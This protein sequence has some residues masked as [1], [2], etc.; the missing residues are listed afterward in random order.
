[1]IGL[2]IV[3][4]TIFIYDFYANTSLNNKPEKYDVKN[5]VLVTIDT[6]RSDH[7]G[8]YGYPVDTTPF[9][10]KLSKKS[11]LFKNAYAQVSSTKPSH[12]SIFTSLYPY[13]HGVLSNGKVLNEGIPTLAE[14][15]RTNGYMTYG[16]TA[17]KYKHNK[18]DLGFE[19]L[20][21]VD[22]TE[23]DSKLVRF[24]PN[25]EYKHRKASYLVDRVISKFKNND[26]SKKFIWVHFYDVHRPF[27]PPLK[28]LKKIKETKVDYL[29]VLIEDQK[30][31]AD[32]YSAKETE[33]VKK[34]Q[35][36]DGEVNFV[37]KELSRL[38][39][40]FKKVGLNKDSLWIITSDHGEGLGNHYFGRHGDAIYNEQIKVPFILHLDSLK[41]KSK[42]I[43]AKIDHVD[44]LPTVL[45]LLSLNK[46][47]PENAQ[48]VSLK[49][50]LFVSSCMD[51]KYIFSRT[52]EFDK[53]TAKS[54]LEKG[55]KYSCSTLKYKYIYET[56]G[57]EYL[58]DLKLDPHELK[59]IASKK[60]N[61]VK[62]LKSK[63]YNNYKNIRPILS[64][65]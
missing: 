34:V 7:V 50:C 55:D 62:K 8:C 2:I 4:S 49:S 28:H 21:Q 36:Y 16:I 64:Q 40:H 13:Q 26:K 27:V 33:L 6:L 25:N 58:F 57:N 15:L 14:I 29:K 43:S 46:S 38:Y 18:L 44:I 65:H 63:I 1:M 10:D 12:A 51:K 19:Y 42:K 3:V 17:V 20:D 56:M 37:D 9:L 47:I 54:T 35:K 32:F 52:P 53:Y 45:D 5:I 11:F 24:G 30:I 48:G 31:P 61:V 39:N 23:D 59:N 41:S 22:F 60:P